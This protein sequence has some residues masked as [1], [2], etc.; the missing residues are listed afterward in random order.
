MVEFTKRNGLGIYTTMKPQLSKEQEIEQ[1]IQDLHKAML[2]DMKA[3]D[4]EIEIA[5]EKKNTH[6]NLIKAKQR[7]E[8][9]NL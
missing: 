3:K 6:Y 2:A 9:I 1:A 8:M 4:K 7:L 5:I